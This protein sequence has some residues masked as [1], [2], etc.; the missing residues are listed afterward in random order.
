MRYDSECLYNYISSNN[1]FGNESLGIRIR[2]KLLA[3]LCLLILDAGTYEDFACC[4]LMC[5]QGPKIDHGL[6]AV[7]WNTGL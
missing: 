3:R 1:I 7:E 6:R 2:M 4:V 5:V